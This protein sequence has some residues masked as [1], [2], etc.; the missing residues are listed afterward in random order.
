MAPCRGPKAPFRRGPS[1]LHSIAT[2]PSAIPY[3]YDAWL[4]HAA[5]GPLCA[6]RGAIFR[7]PGHETTHVGRGVLRVAPVLPRVERPPR[8][9]ATGTCGFTVGRIGNPSQEAIGPWCASICRPPEATS[10]L[11][12]RHRST[13]H[14]R[15]GAEV[16]KKSTS[17]SARA[18]VTSQP[19]ASSHSHIRPCART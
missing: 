2:R 16:G 10:A 9:S 7:G 17:Q 6:E 4:L 12:V 8:S 11:A 19:L 13:G 1:R 3:V 15:V 14:P 5:S 18:E